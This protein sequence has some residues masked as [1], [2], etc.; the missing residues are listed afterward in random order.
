MT[1]MRLNPFSGALLAFV[2]GSSAGMF[3]AAGAAAAPVLSDSNG[4]TLYFFDKDVGG[5][6]SCYGLCAIAWPPAVAP[7]GAE[8]RDGY[9][10]VQRNNGKMQWAHDGKPLYLY[11][12][13]SKPGDMKGDGAEQVWHAARP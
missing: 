13:D 10:L 2:L 1:S 4:M 6:S 8:A 7:A 5:V 11:R 3:A 12:K 9:S